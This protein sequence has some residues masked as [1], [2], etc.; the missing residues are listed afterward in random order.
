LFYEA[1]HFSGDGKKVTVS[2][3]YCLS[4]FLTFDVKVTAMG[5]V[6]LES[7]LDLNVLDTAI[8]AAGKTKVEIDG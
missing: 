4:T 1:A 3:P 7:M 6:A 8:L 5:E 2:Y